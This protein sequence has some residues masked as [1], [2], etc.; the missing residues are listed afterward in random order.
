MVT[1]S[2]EVGID[3]DNWI[4]LLIISDSLTYSE[5]NDFQCS[6]DCFSQDCFTFGTVAI[7]AQAALSFL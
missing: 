5:F 6:I 2:N 3:H 4:E 1:S 7:L